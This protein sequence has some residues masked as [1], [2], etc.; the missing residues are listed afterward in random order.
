VPHDCW[1]EYVA[2]DEEIARSEEHALKARM[3]RE[4]NRLADFD[5]IER[6][7]IDAH[8]AE[9]EAQLVEGIVAQLRALDPA[10]R[11]V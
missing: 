10:W 5:R 6:Q 4:V 7:V 2:R 8:L 1:Q 3:E 9:L 11:R